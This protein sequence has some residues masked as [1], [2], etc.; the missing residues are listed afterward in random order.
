MNVGIIIL[1]AGESKRMGFPKQ[2]LPINKKTMLI[3]L[4]DEAIDTRIGPIT[5]V[6]GA[7]KDKIA[8]IFEN[9]PIN[10]IDNSHWQTGMASSIKMGLIGTYMMNKDVE[11]VIIMSSDMPNVTAKYLEKLAELAEENPEK[12][13]FASSYQNTIGIPAYFRRNKFEDLLNLKNDEGAK[14]VILNAGNSVFKI[15]SEVIGFDIDTKEDYLNYI[16]TKN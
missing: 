7:H 12:D 14:K 9:I 16:N 5:V 3:Q 15:K 2:L 11:G 8:P 4:I 13:I 10:I 6:I 1:A